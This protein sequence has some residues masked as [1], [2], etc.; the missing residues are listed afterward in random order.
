MFTTVETFFFFFFF[1][2]ATALSG[3]D[4][5]SDA[6]PF[7]SVLCFNFP[8]VYIDFLEIVLHVV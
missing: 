4:R 2:G 7:Y 6:P 1:I 5:P 3:Q 8:L